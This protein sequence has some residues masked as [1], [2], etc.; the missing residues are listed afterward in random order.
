MNF[1]HETFVSPLTW[2]YGSEE[3]RSL[4]SEKNK[5]LLL[6]RFWIALA[7][8]QAECGIVS[9][10]QVEDLRRHAE[11]VNLERSAEIERTVRHDLM[12]EVM[13]FA[14][15]CPVGGGIIHLGAT[16]N[17]ALDNM[18]ALRMRASLELLSARLRD[19]LTTIQRRI[20][21][22]AQVPAMAFTHI[23][24]AEPTTI[25]YRIACYGQDLLE[26]FLALERLRREF[27]G[28]GIKG[29]VGTAAGYADLLEGTGHSVSD[30]ETRVMD[31]LGLRAFPIATQ[32]MP[33]RQELSLM[34]LLSELAGSLHRFAL[35][36]RLLQGRMMGEWMEEFG[37]HQ[38][39]SSAMPFKRNPVAA[40]NI[41][42]LA[43]QIA[44]QVGVAW[45]NHAHTMLE[46]TLDDSGN[47]RIFLPEALLLTDEILTR[48]D[49]LLGNLAIDLKRVNQNLETYG[50]F[51]ASE[52]VLLAAAKRGG[53]RQALHETVRRHCLAAWD[54]TQAGQ[55]NP[56]DRSLASDSE[57][58]RWLEPDRIMELMDVAAYV[59]DAPER[60]R[61]MADRIAESLPINDDL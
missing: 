4:W 33:R 7:E 34:H 54:A 9:S 17:D 20:L 37:E 22:W 15:Q 23:Q 45:Q 35:D 52:R 43:R 16:S 56:L 59:G 14:E 31:K 49:K 42:S 3:M 36:C 40:E 46:R 6:R 18:D 10:E 24:P 47:R 2:R 44:S 27:R 25:G 39:G 57:I 5:R 11:E 19:L 13:A 38:V 12:A 53:D 55:E 50:K 41:C 32:T 26:D 30:L 21:Q 58:Q 1:S 51:A 28:K 60:A 48:S 8:G 29:A 61:A